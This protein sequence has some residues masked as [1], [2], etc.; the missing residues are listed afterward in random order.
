MTIMKAV[1][2]KKMLFC[3]LCVAFG[4][5]TFAG[6][7]T[8]NNPPAMI[9]NCGTGFFV[10]EGLFSGGSSSVG[11]TGK[12]FAKSEATFNALAEINRLVNIKIKNIINNLTVALGFSDEQTIVNAFASIST[13]NIEVDYWS[14]PQI[15][16]VHFNKEENTLYVMVAL[17]DDMISMVA[18]SIKKRILTT[19]KTDPALWAKFQAQNG[20]SEL[21][22]EI[23]K[24]FNVNKKYIITP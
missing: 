6:C 9:P 20:L 5:G 21:E 10:P 14:E 2:M 7:Q 3:L 18:E 16:K 13:Q 12:L 11:L 15:K 22:K 4:F 19:I 1:L 23:N 17:D 24:A 8:A